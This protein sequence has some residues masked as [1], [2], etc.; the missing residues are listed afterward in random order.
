V[1]STLNNESQI[2][3]LLQLSLGARPS[4]VSVATLAHAGRAQWAKLL[5]LSD[6]HHVVLRAFNPLR[7]IAREEE[8]AELAEWCTEIL[9]HEH[10]RIASALKFLDDIC[11]KLEGQG[12]QITVMKSLDHWPDIGN[13]LDLYTRSDPQRVSRA[14]LETFAASPKGKTWG[15]RLARKNNFGI[16]GLRESVEIH[17]GVLGQTGEH[18]ALA[19][20]F[21]RRRV[22]QPVDGYTFMVPAPEEQIVAATLQRMYRHLYIRVCDIVNTHGILESGKLDRAELRYAADMGGIWPGV[23]TYLRIVTDFVRRYRGT[24]CQLSPEVLAGARF[25]IEEV[26]VRGIWL[27]VPVRRA[28]RLYGAQLGRMARR[29]D[30]HGVFR[31]SLLPPLASAARLVYKLT[32]DHKGI[33]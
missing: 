22:P 10:A 16:E 7:Q 18:T 6:S 30:L 3:L 12:I 17:H 8:H 20:R 5:A 31:L 19:R 27:R 11:V 23:A 25:G 21:C 32:G 26:T 33:W 24:A 29:R 28:V 9:A 2:D 1:A 14:M 4:E 15:D 13:D